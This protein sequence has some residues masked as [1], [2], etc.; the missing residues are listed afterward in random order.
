MAVWDFIG[1]PLENS[2]SAKSIINSSYSSIIGDSLA[3]VIGGGRATNIY[4][5]DCK[6]VIDWEKLCEMFGEKYFETFMKYF[7]GLIFGLGGDTSVVFGDK[8]AFTYKG[9][10]FTSKRARVKLEVTT[11]E[12]GIPLPLT[13]ALG[14]MGLLA[15]ALVLRFKYGVYNSSQ[16]ISATWDE[17]TQGKALDLGMTLIVTLQPRWLKLMQSLEQ[18]FFLADPQKKADLKITVDALKS[19][20]DNAEAN[21]KSLETQLAAEEA[22]VAAIVP[23]NATLPN[24][25]IILQWSVSTAQAEISKAWRAYYLSLDYIKLSFASDGF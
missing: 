10:D 24:S 7:G 6:M 13:L 11:T 8:N 16:K 14:S 23:P 1:I 18:F 22:R 9:T 2:K 12:L 20:L 15:A 3:F 25:L 21:L 19:K 4:G 5:G 17:D